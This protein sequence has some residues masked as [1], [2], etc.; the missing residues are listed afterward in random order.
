MD[1]DRFGFLDRQRDD[2]EVVVVGDVGLDRVGIG[3]NRSMSVL[4]GA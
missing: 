1:S 4:A 2:A 3:S